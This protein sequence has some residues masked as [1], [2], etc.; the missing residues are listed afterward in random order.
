MIERREVT[1]GAEECKEFTPVLQTVFAL[2]SAPTRDSSV[3]KTQAGT[4]SLADTEDRLALLT[5][6]LGGKEV[7][8][9]DMFKWDRR[10]IFTY[11]LGLF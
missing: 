1:Q 10:L 3:C 2:L 6:T 4:N 11:I 5:M 7:E 8:G 9:G